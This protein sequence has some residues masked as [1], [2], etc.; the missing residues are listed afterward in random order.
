VIASYARRAGPRLLRPPHARRGDGAEEDEKLATIIDRSAASPT[1]DPA[2]LGDHVYA[3]FPPS[4][5]PHPGPGQTQVTY[6][7]ALRSALDK[8]IVRKN[9][10]DPS[11]RTSAAWA[12][13]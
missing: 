10:H 4:P 5:R 8:L 6:A 13:S 2:R 9:G 12:A 3:P 1:P 11:G 7:G